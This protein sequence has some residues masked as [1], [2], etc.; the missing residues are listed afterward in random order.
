MNRDLNPGPSDQKSDALP[1]ELS[2]LLEKPQP[3]TEVVLSYKLLLLLIYKNIVSVAQG[4]EEIIFLC[5]E[6]GPKGESRLRG[7]TVARLLQIRRLRVQ[8]TSRSKSTCS[9]TTFSL[10]K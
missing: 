4:N 10:T 5:T 3:V 6:N 8:I 9:S 1:T 7:A 2:R